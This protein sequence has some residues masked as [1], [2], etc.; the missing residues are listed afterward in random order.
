MNFRNLA[1]CFVG[2]V[3]FSATAAAAATITH[4]TLSSNDATNII[5]DTA[6]GR[7]YTQ[8]DAFNLSV[9][10][11]EA[12]IATGSGSAYEGWSV[13]TSVEADEFIAAALGVANTPCDGDAFWVECGTIS[14]WT[15]GDFGDSLDT[16]YDFFGFYNTHA[17]H[18]IGLVEILYTGRVY[19]FDSWSSIP[20][21]DSYGI[22]DPN[23]SINLLLYQNVADVPVPAAG[24]LLL[25]A[26]GGIGV[27][28]RRRKTS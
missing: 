27:L 28:R 11:T 19:S 24:L 5:T 3:G 17:G 14:G 1:L 12:L 21:L 9:A 18:P 23:L 15:D 13:A 7:Q 2:A 8:F 10:D 20:S 25:S 6:T 22:A 4:G 26:L 16:S